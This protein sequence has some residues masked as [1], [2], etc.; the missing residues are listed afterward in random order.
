MGREKLDKIM[1]YL[2]IV[3]G[4]MKNLDLWKGSKINIPHKI[5]SALLWG[6]KGHMACLT[7]R[8]H[9]LNVQLNSCLKLYTHS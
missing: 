6:Q 7:N 3:R 8:F 1:N 9:L 2:R 5:G 4:V